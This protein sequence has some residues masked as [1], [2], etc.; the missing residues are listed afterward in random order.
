MLFIIMVCLTV[1]LANGKRE[2][3]KSFETKVRKTSAGVHGV[4][5]PR[6][7]EDDHRPAPVSG[8]ATCRA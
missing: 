3:S 6:G 4:G 8:V 2:A 5:C 7:V 1:G